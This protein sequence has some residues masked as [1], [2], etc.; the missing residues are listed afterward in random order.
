LLFAAVSD[1]SEGDAVARAVLADL[2]EE[3]LDGVD[4]LVVEAD[5]DVAGLEAGR[6]GRPP[7]PSLPAP[8]S[9]GRPP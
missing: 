5:D 8:D 6:S 4:R 9:R 3:I 7:D 1:E 2:A